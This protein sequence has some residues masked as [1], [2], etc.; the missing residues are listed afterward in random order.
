MGV[1]RAEENKQKNVFL[2]QTN[3]FG[4][5]LK[6]VFFPPVPIIA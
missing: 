1:K 3:A 5:V 6:H 4:F 2:L